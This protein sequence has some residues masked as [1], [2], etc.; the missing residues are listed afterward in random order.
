MTI[1]NLLITTAIG[2]LGWIC[3]SLVEIK[4]NL[5]TIKQRIEDL[6][7]QKDSKLCPER[8]PQLL[9]TEP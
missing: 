6:P 5:A 1:E 2:I 4:T 9:V 7:C 8:T 3:G